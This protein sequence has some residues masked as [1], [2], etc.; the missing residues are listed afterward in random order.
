[1]S[2]N[3]SP[4][5]P[6]L[7]HRLVERFGEVKVANEGESMVAYQ[8]T[9]LTASRNAPATRSTQ[10]MEIV[11]PGEYYRVCCPRCGDTRFRLWVHHRVVEFP[12]L[13]ICYNDQKTCYDSAVKREAFLF[14]VFKSRPPK[15]LPVRRGQAHSG[16]LGEVDPAGKLTR[17][18]Q[19]PVSHPA[20]DYLAGRGYDPWELGRVYGVSYCESSVRYP[21]CRDRIII[22]VVMN[23]KTVGWQARFIGERDWKSCP[24]PKYWDLPGMAKRMMFYNH[25]QAA[26][27]PWTGLQ[28]G[29]TDVW[30]TGPMMMGLLG[31]TVSFAQRQILSFP[32]FRTKPIVIMLDGDARV[33]NEL[34]T[35]QLQREHPGG[36]VMVDLPTDTD[37]G[38]LSPE[39]NLAT[40][41]AAAKNQGVVLPE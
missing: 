29:V 4:L 13:L 7:Y 37:P 39:S 3:S 35:D 18:D 21:L 9:A 2:E 23:G 27:A 36:V 25:D 15:R 40:I 34:I 31:S 1:M 26:K 8:K 33:E 17:L 19:L 22:P 30:S 32:P 41:Y 5:S 12:W 6:Q 11:H 10:K 28:E 20:N 24:V 14:H 16:K 38:D